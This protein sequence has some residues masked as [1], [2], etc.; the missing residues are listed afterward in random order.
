MVTCKEGTCFLLQLKIALG[1]KPLIA[2]ISLA[3]YILDAVLFFASNINQKR[4]NLHKKFKTHLFNPSVHSFC[5][6]VPSIIINMTHNQWLVP[7]LQARQL[8]S[9]MSDPLEGQ[10]VWHPIIIHRRCDHH[11][12]IRLSDTQIQS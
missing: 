8:I 2:R 5:F 11:R 3:V 1:Q 10:P 12:R 4:E 7:L 9:E 6:R